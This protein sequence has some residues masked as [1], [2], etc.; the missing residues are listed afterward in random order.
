MLISDQNLAHCSSFYRQD[1]FFLN[2]FYK[3]FPP[4]ISKVVLSEEMTCSPLVQIVK[5]DEHLKNPHP[6]T[7]EYY[8]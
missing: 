3:S 1:I 4:L 2:H 7:D 5:S 6:L 8:K